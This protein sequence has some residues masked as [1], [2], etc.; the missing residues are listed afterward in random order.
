MTDDYCFGSIDCGASVGYDI[1]EDFA[2]CGGSCLGFH[3]D[4]ERSSVFEV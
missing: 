4:G 1:V 3:P 2:V